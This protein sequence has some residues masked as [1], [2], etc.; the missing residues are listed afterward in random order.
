MKR[1]AD[2]NTHEVIVVGG[3]IAG[4]SAAIYLGRA[5]RDV[6]VIDSGH[7]MAK[8]EPV[9][10]NYLGFPNGVG[11]KE[12]LK[13]GCIQARRYG[14]RFVRDE[15]KTV[16]A[17]KSFFV[18][19]G[20]RKSYRTKRLLVATGIFHL[21]PE[22]PG[23]KECLGH[24]MFFCKDCDGYRVRGKRIAIIGTSNETVEY[25]LGMLDYSACV[26]V[27]T[28]GKRPVWDKQHARWLAEY[29]IPV[30]RQPIRDVDHRKRKIRALEFASDAAIKID[31]IFTTRGDIFHNQ[32]AK[33]LGAQL[34]PDGQIKV[35]QCMRT[36]VPRLYAAGCV[37]PANC[38]MIIAAGQGAAAAQAIN[39]DVFEESLAS[40][41]LRRFREEQLENKKTVP[42]ISEP[43]PKR[44]RK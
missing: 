36:S 8:W 15:I 14:A 27:A 37:T 17:R 29:E 24:S 6:L 1:S 38:Q 5:Q 40:H 9:V 35:D 21:P 13:N 39:R 43:K 23:V 41:S 30:A 31:Y 3:G 10:Q 42:E 20:K 22:I 18:L 34:D 26:V 16:S 44:R 4:L 2:P 11:G 12:L 28:N 32:L 19:K 7:S 33:K 25:A